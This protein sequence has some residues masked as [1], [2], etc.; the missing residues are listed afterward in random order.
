MFLRKEKLASGRGG[1]F[2]EL[3]AVPA[4]LM[5]CD[6]PDFRIVYLNPR[7]R[8][9]LELIKDQLPVAPGDILGQSIDI[10]HKAPEHQRKLLSDPANLPHKATIELGETI[11]ELEIV[12]RHDTQ[13]VYI[14]PML[15]W[16][17]VTEKVA[18]E[19][20]ANE[21][22]QMVDQMPI[23]AMFME[24]KNFT[25]TYMNDESLKTLRGIEHLL[26]C[27]ADE[28]VGQCV[29]IFHKSPPHQRAILADPKNLPHRA[30]IRLGDET[31]DLQVTPVFNRRGT[32][33][34]AMLT[35]AVVTA[36]VG[37]SAQIGEVVA[38]VSASAGQLRSSAENMS[39]NAEETTAQIN[40]VAAATEQLSASI[41]EIS[42]QVARSTGSARAAVE[43]VEQSNAM[44]TS[45][46]DNAAQIGKVLDLITDIAGQTN[47]LAL[48]ATIEA[49]RAGDAGK[50]FAVVA[51][52][53]KNLA[54]Q[55]ARAT[56]EIATQITGIRG[57]TDE[58]VRQI[59]NIGRAVQELSEIT[60]SISAA[61]EEQAASTQEVALNTTGVSEAA[62][63]AGR[64]AVN[65]LEAVNSLNDQSSRLSSSVEEF[66]AELAK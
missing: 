52:E 12:A 4:A 49:A 14:G 24:L 1:A 13:G 17:V 46:S 3:D 30:N 43:Q 60:G 39:A 65:I 7:S 50:G 33:V 59:R 55:T 57:A 25:I 2:R 35:W 23:A 42:G 63:E 45:L 32:Y 38:N 16:N 31:L 53:V 41:S 9:L 48:N 10:F 66:T 37:L 5:C 21:L 6:L 15:L 47:L 11:L 36:Q 62:I 54:S 61:V 56:E 20:K 58:A 51:S 29:D 22:R 64:V 34:G 44:I 8:Q 19:R 28:I 27:K 40:A 18:A 26:P